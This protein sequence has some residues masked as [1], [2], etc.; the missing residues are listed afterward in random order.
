MNHIRKRVLAL[1]MVLSL[2]LGLLPAFSTPAEAAG[3]TVTVGPGGDLPAAIASLGSSGGIINLTGDIYLTQP[4]KISTDI[5]FAGAGT[6]RAN[7]DAWTSTVVAEGSGKYNTMIQITGGTTTIGQGITVDAMSKCRAISVEGDRNNPDAPGAPTLILDGCTIKKGFLEISQQGAGVSAGFGATVEASGGTIFEANSC[8]TKSS[9]GGGGLYVQNKATAILDDV[10]F[11]NN[12]ANSGGAIYAYQGTVTCTVNTAFVGN[13]ASQRGGAIH[14]HGLVVLNSTTIITGNQSD[15]YGGAIYVS[16]SPEYA[17]QLVMRNCTV[18]GNKAGN[19]GG[20]VFIAD[21]ARVFIGGGTAIMDN[22]L[23]ASGSIPADYLKNNVYVATAQSKLI[24]YSDLQGE[25]GISTSNPYWPKIVTYSLA[26][27]GVDFPAGTGITPDPAYKITPDTQAQISYDSTVWAIMDAANDPQAVKEDANCI[28]GN[29]WLD[30]NPYYGTSGNAVIFDF[31][32]PGKEALTYGDLAVGDTLPLPTVGNETVSDVSFKFAGWHTAPVGGAKLTD[33][34][35]VESGVRVY[36]AHWN[37]ETGSGGGGGVPGKGDMYLVYFNLNY[38]GAGFTTAYVT[39]GTFTFTV[40]YEWTNPDTGATETKTDTVE[41]ELPFGFPGD[42]ARLGYTFQGWGT[43]PDSTTAVNKGT[44]A[45]AAAISTL[46]GIWSPDSHRLRWDANGGTGGTTTTQDYGTTVTPPTTPPKRT[47]YAFTGWY[48]DKGCTIPLVSG[49]LVRGDATYYAGWSPNEY[50]ITWDVNYTAGTVTTVQQKYDDDLLIMPEPVRTGYDFGGW[51]TGPNGTGTRAEAYGTVTG[52]ETFYAFWVQGIIDYT[53]TVEWDDQDDNDAVRPDSI[54]VELTRNDLPTGLTHTLTA[55]DADASGNKW[56]HTFEN[57][58]QTD[59]ISQEYTYSVAITSPVSD[60]YSYGIENK[61]ATLGYIL[62]TH[63]LITRDVAV[64]VAWDDD[65]DRDGERPSSVRVQLCADD[66]PVAD[67][68]AVTTLTGSGNAWTYTFQDVQKYRDGGQEIVYTIDVTATSPGELDAYDVAYSDYT[69]T[70]T[71]QPE[72]MEQT[73]TVVWA[74]D[75][76]RD[77]KRPASMLVQLY[78]DNVPLAERYVLLSD[79]NGW[80][81]TWGDLYR[82]A[83]GGREV[84]YEAHVT[85]TLVD[86]TATTTGMTIEMTYVP[87]S[88]RIT[89]FVTWEDAGDVD[90]LRPEKLLLELVADDVPTGDQQVVSASTGWTAAW[91][92]YMIYAEGSRVEYTFAVVDVPDGYDVEYF[93]IYDTSGLSAVLTHDRILEDQTVTMAWDDQD[94]VALAR[95]AKVQVMLYADGVPLPEQTAILAGDDWTYTFQAM[96]AYR[97]SGT[98]IRYSAYVTSDVGSYIPSTD[99]LHITMGYKIETVDVP[100]HI[101]WSDGDNA[102][103]LRPDYVVVTLTIDGEPT[104]YQSMATADNGWS[105]C[106][107]GQPAYSSAAQGIRINYGVVV[108]PPLGYTAVYAGTYCVLTASTETISVTPVIHWDDNSDQYGQRPAKLL[109]SL[110]ANGQPTG[111]TMEIYA[112]DNWTGKTFSGL[113]KYAAGGVEIPYSVAVEGAL[114]DYTVA[115]V[116]MDVYLTHKASGEG[117]TMDYTAE[118]VWDD[119]GNALASRPATAVLTVYANGAAYTTYTM[120]R[121]DITGDHRWSHTFVGLPTRI[122]GTKVSYTVGISDIPHYSKVIN[123]GSIILTQTVDVVV[124]VEWADRSDAD[125]KRPASLTLDLLADKRPNGTAQNVSGSGNAWTVRFD[126][127]PVWSTADTTKQTAYTYQLNADTAAVLAAAG[128]T[129]DYH[130]YQLGDGS[131]PGDTLLYTMTLTLPAKDNGGGSGGGGGGGGGG[132]SGGGGGGGSSGGSSSTSKTEQDYT[133]SGAVTDSNGNPIKGAVVTATNTSTGDQYTGT[134]DADGKY[135]ITVPNGKY[136]I[137][138]QYGGS[139]YG[140]GTV[141]VKNKDLTVPTIKL[142]KGAGRPVAAYVNGYVDG[143]FRPGNA[144]ARCE[145]VAIIAR[146]S[147]DYDPQAKYPISFPD[148]D[149]SVWYGNYLG[150][151]ASKGIITGYTD[152]TFRGMANIDKGE[153]TAIVARWLGLGNTGK[154]AYKDVPVGYWAE[155]YIA[156]LTQ[157]GIVGGNDKGLYGPTAPIT[158]AEVVKMVNGMLDRAPDTDTLDKLVEAHPKFTDVTP[159][160][161]AYHEVLEAAYDHVHG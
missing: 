139:S 102:G 56:S 114:T 116:G 54:T 19:S 24:V 50:T 115:V 43:A 158:R 77:G 76:D 42:P 29:L 161:W 12:S 10:T 87:S 124:A 100:L 67:G 21:M 55:D 64:Y 75:N 144:I 6:I 11:A 74:D 57:L 16:A 160:H 81:Y 110:L 45:P 5:V 39:A 157:A 46:Y 109:V 80:E 90:G 96:P 62:M 154:S 35:T 33:P 78:A 93:G 126:R 31:N 58:P 32:L 63:T 38:E 128:Y 9:T 49:T 1:L 148:V 2:T 134:T 130:S 152:G 4:A 83:D 51:Y 36:Y 7:G 133:I 112:A 111:K 118:L 120:T 104:K 141:T 138:V 61:S 131:D 156:Q 95:P 25:I 66:A 47:G 129:I 8:E 82:Y 34:L 106:F 153:F 68:E 69:A 40:E 113:A 127:Q 86:Y 59:S 119:N 137:T 79:A 17:G 145:V 85:S 73:V 94:D 44:W 53:V 48:L 52:N 13:Y 88:T 37:I 20:G 123:D 101:K 136:T 155:G 103:G 18:E 28:D 143:T 65:S 142:P 71:H 97:D 149:P 89:A 107:E 92:N 151:C 30:I 122:N 135:E 15:Q 121:E 23:V 91:D 140:G 84:V 105:V 146:V 117:Y 26:T 108:T 150:Y 99:G 3:G 98:A 22:E 60:K 27:S 132:G 125:H 147:D 14:D 41:V 70:L 159:K 72:T